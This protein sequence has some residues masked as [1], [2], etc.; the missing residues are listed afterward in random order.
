MTW[1]ETF[2]SCTLH[3]HIFHR[4]GQ[5]SVPCLHVAYCA[6]KVGV[7][8]TFGSW[9]HGIISQ[10]IKA[11]HRWMGCWNKRATRE[12]WWMT[13]HRS[14]ASLVASWRFNKE[15][16]S[17]QVHHYSYAMHDMS[18]HHHDIILILLWCHHDIIVICD[19]TWPIRFDLCPHSCI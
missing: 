3:Q 5:E 16:S 2:D 18:M 9:N 7:N 6:Y 19:M 10:D 17:S 12:T 15:T 13:F 1:W 11:C 4:H 14:L 8:D